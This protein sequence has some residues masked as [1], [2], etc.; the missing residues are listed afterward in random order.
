MKIS[1]RA[2]EL[3][4]NLDRL[5]YQSGREKVRGVDKERQ[6]A[7]DMLVDYVSELEAKQVVNDGK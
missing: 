5:A 6:K 4:D 1:K 2:K 7:R 3:I